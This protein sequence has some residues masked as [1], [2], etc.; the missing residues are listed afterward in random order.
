MT[1]DYFTPDCVHEKQCIS[2]GYR[3]ANCKHNKKKD[4]YEP[5]SPFIWTPTPGTPAPTPMFPNPII[6]CDYSRNPNYEFS[7]HRS[8][9]SIIYFGGIIDGEKTRSS[10]TNSKSKKA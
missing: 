4:F 8:T 5:T 1:K 3:C 10:K 9:P 7:E 6:T 2:K